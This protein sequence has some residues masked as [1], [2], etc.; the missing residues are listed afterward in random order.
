MKFKNRMKKFFTLTR[1][2]AGGFTL[3][4]LIVVI[5]ILGILAGVAIPAYSGYIKKANAAADLQLLDAVNTAF[6]AACLEN[7]TDASLL[8]PDAAPEVPLNDDGTVDLANVA[9][10]A[11]A[12]ARYFEGNTTAAFKQATQLYFMYGTGSFSLEPVLTF[13]YGGSY[14][15]FSADDVAALN[16]STFGT[17]GA[18]GLMERV[19]V[20]TGLASELAGEH[21]GFAEFL[22]GNNVYM[23]EAMGYDLNDATQAAAFMEKWNE[24]VAQ[25]AALIN[26]NDP[27]SEAALNAARN[28]IMANYAVLQAA[29]STSTDTDTLLSNMQ[30]GI[31]VEDVKALINSNDIEERQQ[32]LS[33]A[34]MMYAMYTS[35]ANGLE[36]SD[37]NKAAAL[38]NA[39]S[40][41]GF[42]ADMESEGF[43]EYLNNSNG[44]AEKDLEGYL[45]ALNM[46][47]SST[48]GNSS[49]VSQLLVNGFEDDELVKALQ[50][51]LG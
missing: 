1:E 45:A 37:P 3:V 40:I 26:P 46:I 13:S 34:A 24:M 50:G 12:F 10:Y 7:G 15:S 41:E 22:A 16:S 28:Q 2:S 49:A 44:Q 9:P 27:T 5:A 11:E 19:D 18:A 20:V 31:G 43:K 39:K 14:I 29:K 32:G 8:E 30:Q 21:E 4:E 38:E 42:M 23:A 25:K 36:D 47:N 17:I 48:T 6:A 35:Y 33:N 51:A